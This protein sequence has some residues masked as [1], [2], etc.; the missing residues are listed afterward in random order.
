MK[1]LLTKVKR[2]EH[3]EDIEISV[4]LNGTFWKVPPKAKV[5]VNETLI[6]DDIVDSKKQISFSG[7]LPDGKHVLAIELCEKDKYQTI[8]EDGK[9]VKD[10][11]L[12]ID[13]ISFDEIEIGFLKYALSKYY[14]NENLIDKDPAKADSSVINL[15][16]NGRW[17]L[18]FTTPIYIWL[19]ENV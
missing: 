9:I 18:E 4:S 3:L 11:L 5:F 16:I 15:G 6:F 19:L 8:I 10:Q 2:M 17:E 14:Y 7:K 13:S 12:N 1:K